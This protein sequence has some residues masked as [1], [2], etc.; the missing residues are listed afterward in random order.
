MIEG[1]PARPCTN[2]NR[3]GSTVA[4]HA[5][6]RVQTPM[7]TCAHVPLRAQG[8]A[9]VSVH[10]RAGARTQGPRQQ[11]PCA[12]VWD[13]PRHSRPAQIP[14]QAPCTAAQSPAR[15]SRG[16]LSQK[17]GRFI[18]RTFDVHLL[19]YFNRAGIPEGALL[20]FAPTTHLFE[21]APMT[22]VQGSTHQ[23]NTT[24]AICVFSVHF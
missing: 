5:Q 17:G 9:H 19:L 15:L 6:R 8:F 3:R 20:V 24:S 7:H 16:P 18:H 10:I 21:Q 23:T 14:T 12:T 2:R 11:V 22:E 4:G 1:D 13:G